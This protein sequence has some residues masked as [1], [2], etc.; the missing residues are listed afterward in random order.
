MTS[1]IAD[2]LSFIGTNKALSVE[3]EKPFLENWCKIR[4]SSSKAFNYPKIC[5][6][7]F[8]RARDLFVL[9]LLISTEQPK[10]GNYG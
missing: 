1:I 4:K 8:H 3:A 2:F 6:Q 5:F 10:Q 7:E 9:I